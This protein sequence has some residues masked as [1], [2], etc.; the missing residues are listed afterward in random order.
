MFQF[1]VY[2]MI[3]YTSILQTDFHNK[4]IDKSIPHTVTIC[5]CVDNI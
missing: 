2:N 4:S 5:V 3:W 1:K